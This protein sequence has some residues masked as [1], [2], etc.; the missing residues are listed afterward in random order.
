[1]RN[2]GVPSTLDAVSARRESALAAEQPSR[3]ASLHLP[4]PAAVNGANALSAPTTAGR[5]TSRSALG[6]NRRHRT[7]RKTGSEELDRAAR[8]HVARQ[9]V[10]QKDRM[11][12][13]GP[14]TPITSRPPLSRRQNC[15]QC[16]PIAS[17]SPAGT[18]RELQRPW[19]RRSR[20]SL[21]SSPLS[22]ATRVQSHTPLDLRHK[23]TTTRT[24]AH[25]L[26]DLGYQKHMNNKWKR[27]KA[28][29]C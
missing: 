19:A 25:E 28:N 13:G 23:N 9:D 6:S 2:H 14:S 5:P 4:L 17:R 18:D 12:K 8:E 10:R 22:L 26:C 7:P 27:S 16:F 11:P 20:E 24:N 3:T 1:M 29:Q 15:V 21:A